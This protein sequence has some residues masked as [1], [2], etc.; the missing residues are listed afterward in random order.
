MPHDEPLLVELAQRMKDSPARRRARGRTPTMPSGYV[1]LGQFVAHDIAGDATPLAQMGPDAERM[2]NYRTPRLDLDH[3]YGAGPSGSPELYDGRGRLRLGQTLTATLAGGRRIA[4]SLGDLPR[5]PDGTATVVDQRNDENLIVA[6]IHV[7]MAKLHNCFLQLL[8]QQP[9]LSAGPAD[10]SLFEQARRLVTW[11]YQWIAVHDFLPRLV[12]RAVLQDIAAKGLRLFPHVYTPADAPMALPLEFTLAAF[13]FGHSMVQ[14][15]YLLGEIVID[16]SRLTNMTKRGG[17]IN[18]AAPALPADHVIEWP[19]FFSGPPGVLNRGQNIDTFITEALYDLPAHSGQ[20]SPSRA[21]SVPPGRF[22]PS[23]PE[24]TLRRG[25]RARLPAGEEFAQRFGFMPLAAQEVAALP[26]DLAF[27]DQPALRGRTPLWYYL[28]REAAVEDTAAPE[29]ER[30]PEP[31]TQKLGTLGGHIVAEVLLQILAADG[32]SIHN[33][34]SGWRPPAFIF[35][36]SNRPRR[37]TSM[38]GVIQMLQEEGQ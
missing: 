10:A 34:G 36:A 5:E 6:Q 2:A 12:R 1:Y 8:E 21:A 37:I 24:L 27:F 19:F 23:L 30:G 13:R 17:G 31:P 7:L 3:L 18:A 4:S 14:E 22:M 25:A 15:K 33:A 9:Q 11:H 20:I 35:G 29:R 16:T 32:E 28:L 38:Q 26:E